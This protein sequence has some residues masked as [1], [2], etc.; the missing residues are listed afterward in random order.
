M[1]RVV[2]AARVKVDTVAV[3]EESRG[4]RASSC[5]IIKGRRAQLSSR[6]ER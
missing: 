4:A 2:G 5:F 1:L 3:E 6:A